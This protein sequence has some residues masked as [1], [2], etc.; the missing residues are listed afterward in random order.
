MASSDGWLDDARWSAAD[1]YELRPS[2]PASSCMSALAAVGPLAWVSYLQNVPHT[3]Q[4][5]TCKAT[6]CH[7]C[8]I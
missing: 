6:A 7:D 5:A 1:W 4:V 8:L 3:A 2:Q